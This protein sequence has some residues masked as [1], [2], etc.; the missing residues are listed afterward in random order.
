MAELLSAVAVQLIGVVEDLADLVV[1]AVE[2]AEVASA[3]LVAV[4]LVE[5]VP[6]G[7]GKEWAVNSV[8]CAVC[9]I[10]DYYFELKFSINEK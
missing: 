6:E 5:V 9:N 2:V 8:Q 3:D 10:G 1:A 7:V 4:D